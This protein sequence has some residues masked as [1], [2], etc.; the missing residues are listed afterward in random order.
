MGDQIE[1]LRNYDVKVYPL[2]ILVDKEGKIFKYPAE[3]PT[4]RLEE[5]IEI[6]VSR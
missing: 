3:N 5:A 2:F 1:L 4:D 6:L